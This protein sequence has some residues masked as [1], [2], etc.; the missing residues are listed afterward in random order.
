MTDDIKLTDD[1]KAAVNHTV[2]WIPIAEIQPPRG[3]KLLLID[4]RLG[5]GTTGEW[6]P[7]SPWTHWQGW[8]KFRRTT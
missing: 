2:Y 3:T 7:G 5:A 8:P 4:E 6:S 1:R